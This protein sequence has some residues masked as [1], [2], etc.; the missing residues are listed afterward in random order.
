MPAWEA[1]PAQTRAELTAL[2]TRLILDHA[3]DG[4][5]SPNREVG[6]DL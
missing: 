6:H 4:D 3:Q 1:L 5:A 2:M